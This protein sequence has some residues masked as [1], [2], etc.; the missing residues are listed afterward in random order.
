MDKKNKL[1]TIS[2]LCPGK[3][4][5]V[6][7]TLESIRVILEQIDSELIIVDTGCSAAFRQRLSVYTDKFVSFEWINDFAAARNAG[8]QVANGQWFMFIDDDEWFEDARPLIRFFT[9]G[10][11]KKY[12]YATYKK[13]NYWDFAMSGYEDCPAV[14][15]FKIEDGYKFESKIHEFY[16]APIKQ[17]KHLDCFV[18]HFGYCYESEEERIKKSL[19]NIIPLREMIAENPKNMH[20]RYQLIQEYFIAKNYLAL[21]DEC[22]ISLEMAEDKA[23][24]DDVKL[25][26]FYL[27]CFLALTSQLRW[28]EAYEQYNNIVEQKKLTGVAKARLY[29]LAVPVLEKIGKFD[30]LRP[31]IDE[32]EKLFNKYKN[33]ISAIAAE[34]CVFSNNP[35]DDVAETFINEHKLVLAIRDNDQEAYRIS[36]DRMDWNKVYSDAMT[37]SMISELV[38]ILVSG[39]ITDKQAELF[40]EVLDKIEVF[41]P[42]QKALVDI[43][44]TTSGDEQL[45][46]NVLKLSSLNY[47]ISYIKAFEYVQNGDYVKA[48]EKL[49]SAVEKGFNLFEA[50]FLVFEAFGTNNISLCDVLEK[51]RRGKFIDDVTR[52]KDSKLPDVIDKM[53][54]VLDAISENDIRYDWL[55]KS[56][57]EYQLI[58]TPL[59]EFHGFEDLKEVFEYWCSTVIKYYS[60]IYKSDTFINETDFLP[61]DGAAAVYISNFIQCVDK[62]KVYALTNL[63]KA[64]STYPAVKLCGQYLLQLYMGR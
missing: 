63:K 47:Y 10:D 35:F 51:I 18:H 42:T 61:D 8:L 7:K 45:V 43:L 48:Q 31:A 50:D 39:E 49:M 34:Q 28:Q 16:N 55:L 24:M 2:L 54:C 58:N 33:N 1:L 40:D 26:A 23:I 30:E 5:D 19:R 12:N 17:I 60:N 3:N 37:N 22:V 53:G 46:K 52:T 36:F 57:V 27:G 6:F 14:R 64:I 13:R 20:A 21:W 44:K 41:E 4:E 62:D 59:E 56:M 32:Y 9:S 25:C 11:Y 38:N 29:V 15:L